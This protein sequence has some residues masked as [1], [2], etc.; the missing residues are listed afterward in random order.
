M[1]Y[2]VVS[3]F[4]HCSWVEKEVGIIHKPFV[5]KLCLLVDDFVCRNAFI[6][7]CS[8]S[9]CVETNTIQFMC[10]CQKSMTA[11]LIKYQC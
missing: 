2:N 4:L 10:I 7:L 5:V 3:D 6:G 1:E 11:T 8:M 9:V